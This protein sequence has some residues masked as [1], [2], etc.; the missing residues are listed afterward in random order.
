MLDRLSILKTALWAMVGALAAVT[1]YRFVY[2]LGAVTNLS[3]QAPWGLWVAFDVMAGVALA[4]GG[5]VL[6]ATVYIFGL[7]R[8]RVFVRPA[9]L[10][11][12]LGY[13]A[14]AVGLLFDLGLPWHIWHPLRYPQIHSVLFEVA[15]CVMLYL[16][17]LA[18]EFAPVVLEHPRLQDPVLRRVYTVLWRVTLPLV[19][20][21][22]ALSTLHQS[23]LGSLFLLTPY[24][25]HPLWYS[26]LLPLLFFVSAVALGLMM[27]VLESLLAR[28]FL[29]HEVAPELV[30]GLARAAVPVLLLYAALRLGDLIVRG[31]LPGA[32]DGS[33]QSALFIGE[34]T[35]SA[36]LPA[37][38]LM[39]RGIR[40]SGMGVGVAA[41][42]TVGGLV[43]HRLDVAVVA[44]ARPAGVG[45][46]PTWMEVVVSLGI[47]AGAVLIFIRFVETLGVYDGHPT[48]PPDRRKP[49]WQAAWMRSLRPAAT[50][51]V[52]RYSLAVVSAASLAV[53][54]LPWGGA[55]PRA[56]PVAPPTS[57][58]ALRSGPGGARDFLL[59]AAPSG[60]VLSAEEAR[61]VFLL[62]G[63]RAGEVVIF[64]HDAHLER[65]GGSAGCGTCHH[66]N[67]PAD[68]STS[69]SACHQDM[70]RPT[71]TFDHQ[72][73][74][75]ALDGSQGCPECHAPGQMKTRAAA[76][77]CAECHTDLAPAGGVLP[78]ASDRWQA[79]PAYADAMHGL[80]VGCHE[81]AVEAAAAEH[82][83][84]MARCDFCHDA[85]RRSEVRA[86][87]PAR[88]SRTWSTAALRAAGHDGL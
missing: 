49:L 46:F 64:D 1:V 59:V 81:R 67:L 71:D 7:E 6:A 88:T 48:P 31:V 36:L 16:T 40:M 22:I 19:I 13:V 51:D 21:G 17:V 75:L 57:Q 29:R 55:S 76:T 54:F 86:L 23:S 47:V 38:L 83:P 41:A 65:E 60:A 62:D 69:C 3:D 85:D 50:G 74:V 37:G 28:R 30:A 12:L 44:F 79:A 33:W 87:A 9:I 14:V 27:V 39:V 53:L 68:R 15:A 45:Y 61:S 82:D 32:L 2:G 80:C 4:A 43:L 8:Y 58:A 18:L 78:A 34:L 73:H 20:L 26:P 35:V 84:H 66:L 72:V 5:F 70:H 25:L 63:D 24:R 10:T 52:R 77:A 42:L 56:T 11:A